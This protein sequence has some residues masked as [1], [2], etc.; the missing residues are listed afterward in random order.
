MKR[1]NHEWQNLVEAD[2]YARQLVKYIHLKPVRPKDKRT[3][4]PVKLR[5]ADE[6]FRPLTKR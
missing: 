5:M 2:G 1:Q 4:I 6:I 3:P